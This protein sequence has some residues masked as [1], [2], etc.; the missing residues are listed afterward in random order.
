MKMKYIIYTFDPKTKE[1][2]GK[3]TATFKKGVTTERADE[4]LKKELSQPFYKHAIYEKNWRS[5]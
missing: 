5:V 3:C 1:L 2:S 4:I